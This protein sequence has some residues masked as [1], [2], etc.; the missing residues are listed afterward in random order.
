MILEQAIAVSYRRGTVDDVEA[1]A[2]I[3]RL[4]YLETFGDGSDGQSPEETAAYLRSAF[5]SEKT[6]EEL[7]G[8][9][10]HFL[11]AETR[12]KVVGYAKLNGDCEVPKCIEQDAPVQLQRIYV[13]SEFHGKGP[14]SVLMRSAL[15]EAERQGYDAVWLGVD[16]NNLRAQEFY[17][18]WDFIEVGEHTFSTDTIT[19]TDLIFS[20]SLEGVP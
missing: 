15:A 6:H 1:L 3:S 13:L 11:L 18:K 4:T 14:G 7:L 10:N 20:R 5:S 12:D 8:E 19:Y 9:A 17:K 2:E 16:R